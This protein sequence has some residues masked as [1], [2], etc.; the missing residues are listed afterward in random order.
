MF[1]NQDTVEWE[2]V[3]KT[4]HHVHSRKP[5]S[6]SRMWSLKAICGHVHCGPRRC[7]LSLQSVPGGV[8]GPCSWAHRTR[9]TADGKQ[10]TKCLT[11]SDASV[12][13]EAVPRPFGEAFTSASATSSHVRPFCLFLLSKAVLSP[14]GVVDSGLRVRRVH[15]SS[16]CE[17]PVG[18]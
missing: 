18:E 13:H 3:V 4:A 8:C 5:A 7:L 14:L 10:R 12:Q 1:G 2:P 11:S 6:K 15:G 9:C 16:L 17:A